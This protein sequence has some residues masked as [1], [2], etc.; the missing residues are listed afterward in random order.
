MLYNPKMLKF[1]IFI[2]YLKNGR[3]LIIKTP[4]RKRSPKKLP[5]V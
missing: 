5:G 2:G 4:G 1:K 3:R